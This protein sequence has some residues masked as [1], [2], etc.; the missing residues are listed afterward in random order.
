M[1][2][3]GLTS[4]LQP[5]D[6]CLNKPFKQRVRMKWTEWLMDKDNHSFTPSGYMRKPNITTVC[7]WVKE[8][9]D[10]LSP[11]IIKKSFKKCSISNSLDGSEDHLI[12]DDDSESDID[13]DPF[14]VMS[15]TDDVDCCMDD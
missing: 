13:I 5:L 4:Q 7:T 11:D 3:G 1:I 15:D 14:D 6:V 9:W 2:P 10:D 12:Y 8:V